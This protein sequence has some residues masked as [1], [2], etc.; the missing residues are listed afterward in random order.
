MHK[1]KASVDSALLDENSALRLS[2]AQL[3][4]I[5]LCARALPLRQTV[6]STIYFGFAQNQVILAK[7]SVNRLLRKCVMLFCSAIRACDPLLHIFC[8]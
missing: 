5:S 3:L 1:N 7:C 8:G 6:D 4:W 2:S